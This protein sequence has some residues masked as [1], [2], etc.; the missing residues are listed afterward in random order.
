[1]RRFLDPGAARL[2]AVA[3]VLLLL[4]CSSCQAERRFNF[5]TPGSAKETLGATKLA[6]IRARSGQGHL[7]IDELARRIEQDDDLVGGGQDLFTSR[8]SR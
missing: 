5:K 3:V 4:C 1:M 2:A 7:T 8:S 6:R